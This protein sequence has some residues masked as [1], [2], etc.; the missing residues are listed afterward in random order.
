MLSLLPYYLMLKQLFSYM[1]NWLFL[2]IRRW[3]QARLDKRTL[4][5]AKRKSP[6]K[7]TVS[8]RGGMRPG[9]YVNGVRVYVG[10]EETIV[11]ARA[12]EVV[13]RLEAQGFEVISGFG[14]TKSR[15]RD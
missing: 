2:P 5:A 4:K 3:A 12:G 6:V 7:V 1:L 9:V 11:V 14:R 13:K 10:I 15:R 8:S